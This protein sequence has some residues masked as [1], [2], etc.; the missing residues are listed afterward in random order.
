VIQV[1]SW[2][3]H[4]SISTP[5]L[6]S[7]LPSLSPSRHFPM[8]LLFP[9]STTV[10]QSLRAR[11]SPSRALRAPIILNTDPLFILPLRSCSFHPCCGIVPLT[12]FYVISPPTASE[13][14]RAQLMRVDLD[15][16]RGEHRGATCASTHG[17]VGRVVPEVGRPDDDQVE[18]DRN[19][20]EVLSVSSVGLSPF[21]D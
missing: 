11:S 6:H 20:F 14:S 9:P 17:R 19:D 1:V 16:K 10:S 5:I 8:T 21:H 4:H 2:A 12:L 18:A 13:L 15:F 3:N 7:R